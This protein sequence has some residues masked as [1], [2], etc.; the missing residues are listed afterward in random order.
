MR[1][2]RVVVG[3]SKRQ[4]LLLERDPWNLVRDSPKLSRRNK[5]QF[6]AP[7]SRQ[8]VPEIVRFLHKFA[9]RFHRITHGGRRPGFPKFLR[10]EKQS[11]KLK[12]QAQRDWREI[13]ELWTGFSFTTVLCSYLSTAAERQEERWRMQRG[14]ELLS[15]QASPNKE[16]E[17]TEKLS[18]S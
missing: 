7:C 11:E 4:Q 13:T 15:F 18:Y 1:R 16:A 14:E 17:V 8:Q 10:A 12:L 2:C 5:V 9:N 6:C 3:V